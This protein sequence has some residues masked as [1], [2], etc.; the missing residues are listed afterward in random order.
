[1][2]SS[3]SR[4]TCSTL[5]AIWFPDAFALSLL[6]RLRDEQKF[7]SADALVSTIKNDIV[8]ARHMLTDVPQKVYC[9]SK[10]YRV[11]ENAHPIATQTIARIYGQQGKLEQAEAI[12]VQ[13]LEL[14]PGDAQLEKE[15]AE[16]KKKRQE[17]P[18]SPSLQKEGLELSKSAE[19]LQCR[20]TVTTRGVARR[21]WC[22]AVTVS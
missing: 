18:A 3:K 10:E 22:W 17:S 8:Q 12:Y 21:A 9:S 15:L 6:H 11:A 19:T 14:S 20:W 1:M 7:A 5:K 16:V 4:Y 13:L 2:A